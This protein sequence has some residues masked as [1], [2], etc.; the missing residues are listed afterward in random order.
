M[1]VGCSA[2]F[3][4]G[5]SNIDPVHIL[6]AMLKSEEKAL[7]LLPME[8]EKMIQARGRFQRLVFRRFS[9][10]FMIFLVDFSGF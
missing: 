1:W 6:L 10:I 4:G 9:G 7:E 3:W 8:S 5:S 2:H